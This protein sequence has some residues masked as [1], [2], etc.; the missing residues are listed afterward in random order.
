MAGT[1]REETNDTASIFVTPVP[2]SA[3][4][5]RARSSG[6][7][8]RSACRP[9]RGPTSR[10][11]TRPGSSGRFN[12]RS[13]AARASRRTRPRPRP[14]RRRRRRLATRRPPG[15]GPRT[16]GCRNRRRSRASPPGRRWA[17]PGRSRPAR[18]AVASASSP[19]GATRFTT[20]HA[21]A[22]STARRR[23]VK[24]SSFARAR[25]HRRASSCVP[26][27]PG[28]IPTAV[29]GRPNTASSAATIRS[30]DS[31]S[32][33]PPPSAKPN[34]D[35]IVGM[36]VSRMASNIPAMRSRLRQP[37]ARGRAGC[38]PS[39][40]RRRRTRARRRR[41][42]PRPTFVRRRRP[43]AGTR[44]RPPSAISPEMAFSASGRD[45]V[46]VATSPPTSIRTSAIV[47]PAA[48]RAGGR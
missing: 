18:P 27:P 9:S 48:R 3:S 5:R 23:P 13:I 20:P 41:R 39:G 33:N 45:S 10:I 24:I 44:P 26:P 30:H 7:I 38:V 2:D 12:G 19:E 31:A 47:R 1:A 43:P 15:P 42:A 4:I 37:A 46:I 40:R 11:V 36:G 21:C 28:T 8:G 34:T 22:S 29:S 32:S 25:P 14:G 16:G 35:A 17:P 6:G